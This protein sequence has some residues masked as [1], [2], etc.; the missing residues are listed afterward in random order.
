MRWGRLVLTLLSLTLAGC[1]AAPVVRPSLTLAPANRPAILDSD[2]RVTPDGYVWLQKLAGAYYENCVSL[3]VI[4]QEDPKQ[5]R[6][7][8]N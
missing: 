2:G 6:Q 8:L 1:A 7:G 4:R 5:C 3:S